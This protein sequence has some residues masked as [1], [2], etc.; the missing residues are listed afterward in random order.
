VQSEV[1]MSTYWP[2]GAPRVSDR[3][4]LAF[5]LDEPDE[6]RLGGSFRY[7]GIYTLHSA[8]A[9][10]A[11]EEAGEPLD[12]LSHFPM[13]VDLYGVADFGKIQVGASVGVAK[14]TP[15]HAQAAQVTTGAREDTVIISRWHW[16]GIELGED[17]LM[18]IGRLNLP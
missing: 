2:E 16:L 5:G 6:L 9:K 13:Q 3:S 1:S 18:R 14:V 10:Q 12:P 11:A 17:V 4:K 8:E 7:M 15:P